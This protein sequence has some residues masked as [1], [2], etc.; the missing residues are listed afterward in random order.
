MKYVCQ[1]GGALGSDLEWETQGANYGVET[2]AYSFKG[3][4][5]KS[6]NLKVLTEDEL[7]I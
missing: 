2:I 5:S 4:N 6:K 3:H 7:A 1:S